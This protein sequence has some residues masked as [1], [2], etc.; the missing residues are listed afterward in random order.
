LKPK[1]L[2]IN[3]MKIIVIHGDLFKVSNKE[4]KILNQL[5]TNHFDAS[6]ED[7]D[8]TLEK[9]ENYLRENISKYK[10]L[11]IISFHHQY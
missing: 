5:Q 8:I 1:Q 7:K 11:G 4:Y 3:D 2:N 6:D 10:Y 9:L